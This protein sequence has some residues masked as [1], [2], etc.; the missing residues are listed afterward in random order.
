MGKIFEVNRQSNTVKPTHQALRNSI[1][2]TAFVAMLS[3]ICLA[4]PSDIAPEIASK[5]ENKKVATANNW[6]AVTANPYA[7]EAA[8]AML[9]NGGSAVDA[10]IAAQLVLGLVEPQSSGIGGGG[11]LLHWHKE[12]NTLISFDG[13]ETAP[14]AVNEEHFLADGKAM[15][16]FEAVVG[17]HAV[18][19]PGLLHM[20]D[21]AHKQYGVLKWSALFQP[22]IRLA[23]QGFIISPRLYKLLQYMQKTPNGIKDPNMAAYFLSPSGH[24]KQ[25]GTRL[26]NPAYAKT[27]KAIASQGI[28]AFYQGTIAD[29]MVAAVQ[30]NAIKKGVLNHSDLIGYSSV[31]REA[32]CQPIADYKVCGA[33]LPASGPIAV[34]QILDMLV[35]TPGFYG[36]AP[37]S[38]AFYHRFSEAS[39]LAFADRD[40]YS[41]DSDFVDVPVKQL[42]AKPYLKKRSHQIPLLHAS[43]RQAKAGDIG[44]ASSFV[45]SQSH[46]LP[47]TTHLSI[48]DNDGNIVS[49]TSSIEMAFGSQIMVNGYLMNNQLTDFS[50]TYQDSEQQRVANRVEGG[51]RPRSSM[52]P[53]LVFNQQT[54]LPVLVIGSPG[55]SKII[56]YVAK[57]MAQHLFLQAR[58]EDAVNSPHIVNINKNTE[59]ENNHQRSNT[60]NN[61]LQSLGHKTQLKDQTSG[62]HAIS[63]AQGMYQG[64]ADSRREGSAIG[65]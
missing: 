1:A 31:S 51:K 17:G 47:S 20:L 3:P 15:G 55:G 61:N 21:Q 54:G 37:D 25:A 29:T 53:M 63:L 33:S 18:G 64:V 5:I 57:T 4:G 6:M 27:L 16:F 39:K 2:L 65:Y 8:A 10:A 35:Q 32:T 40:K 50:F 22:A 42:L 43:E 56:D 38:A 11:F 44:A 23:E 48:V 62:I 9:E 36:L 59:V 19:T 12:D 13:R 60:L 34:M 24:V 28:D 49:M 30:N 26:K 14:K 58:L 52:A 7:S 45:Q 41:A 46:E